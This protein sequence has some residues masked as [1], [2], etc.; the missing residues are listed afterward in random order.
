MHFYL[1][2]VPLFLSCFQTGMPPLL[3]PSRAA[4]HK[5]G[6]APPCRHWQ[7]PQNSRPFP[8]CRRTRQTL[9]SRRKHGK[10]F[11]SYPF[12]PA[13]ETPA[14]PGMPSRPSLQMRAADSRPRQHRLTT[15]RTHF[16]RP[17]LPSPLHPL[18]P[19]PVPPLLPRSLQRQGRSQD[20][21][22][23]YQRT[24]LSC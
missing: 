24:H 10:P 13:R 22:P 9:Q 14:P 18:F 7:A 15:V 12:S 19:P 17:E 23:W 16:Q 6:S 8:P 4:A 21:S 3:L 5:A 1:S 2:F 20:R 11:R